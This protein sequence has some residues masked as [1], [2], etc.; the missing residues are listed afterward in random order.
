MIVTRLVRQLPIQSD[1]AKLIAGS[2][3]VALSI[4]LGMVAIAGFMSVTLPAAI[5]AALA[6]VG[7]AAYAATMR[8]S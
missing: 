3:I 4:S 1:L 5:P 7:A 8:H 2:I 6:A